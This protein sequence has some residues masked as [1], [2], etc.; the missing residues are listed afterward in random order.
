MSLIRAIRAVVLLISAFCFIPNARA[1]SIVSARSGLVNFAE[2]VVLVDGQSVAQKRGTF[3]RLND[4]SILMTES[5]R[6]EILLTPDTYLRVGENS[7]VRLISGRLSDTRVEVLA[8]SAILD[9]A[10]SQSGDFVTIVFQNSTIRIL[11]PGTCR[12]DAEPPQLR[13]YEGQA[14][15]TRDGES[16]VTVAASQ[17]LPLDG[18]PIVRRFTDGSD[19]LLDLWSAERRSLI[20]SKMV[21][22]AQLAEPLLDAGGGGFD[23]SLGYMP[24]ATTPWVGPWLG[25]DNWGYG[26]NP[27]SSLGIYPFAFLTYFPRYRYPA[28]F[29]G[30]SFVRGGFGFPSRTLIN[31]RPLP[32]PR[33][34]PRPLPPPIRG[35][36]AGG[37]R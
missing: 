2:G 20:S 25:I 14:E 9:S 32:P 6:A 31:P 22:N 15:F 7:S 37:R 30:R 13:V 27:V 24:Y 8:G 19:G 12:I 18:A 21:I 16:P 1:Q 33:L 35:G 23:P 36:H 17:L 4:G 11:K 34:A 5:G 26:L 29:P 10:K 3:A 28:T